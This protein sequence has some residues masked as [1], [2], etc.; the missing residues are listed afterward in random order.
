MINEY[1]SSDGFSCSQLLIPVKDMKKNEL[2]NM[3]SIC[4]IIKGFPLSLERL[5]GCTK[6]VD[7][8]CSN[9]GVKTLEGLD[10][11]V[12]LK[13]LNCESNKIKELKHIENCVNL[14]Y[15]NIN[16]NKIVTLH[17]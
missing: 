16:Y 1:T 11:C 8:N 13:R 3:I 4:F 9:C 5:Y 2:D 15:L 17:P 12:N 7:I 14:E 10:R 6:L